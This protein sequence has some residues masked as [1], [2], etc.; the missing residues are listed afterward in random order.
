MRFIL[1]MLLALLGSCTTTSEQDP[2]FAPV[3]LTCN[4][5][6]TEMVYADGVTP[7]RYDM[8]VIKT[9]KNRCKVHYKNSPCAKKVIKR[10]Q[11]SYWIVCGVAK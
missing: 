6:E 1:L 10:S 7:S 8:E 2:L 4:D 3:P 11:Y 5:V 9:A